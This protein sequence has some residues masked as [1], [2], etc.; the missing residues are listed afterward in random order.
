MKQRMIEMFQKVFQEREE[1]PS[2]G[3]NKKRI[4]GIKGLWFLFVLVVAGA[5]IIGRVV[6]G[7][8]F[9]NIPYASFLLTFLFAAIFVCILA[10]SIYIS[11]SQV[12]QAHKWL[13]EL[14]GE[15]I[16]TWGSG[17]KFPFPFFGFVTIHE[18]YIGEQLMELHMNDETLEGFGYGDVEFVDI[19]APVESTL[20][21]K[22]IDPVKAVYYVENL[23]QA[24]QDKM[25]SA[26]RSFLGQYTIE[27]ANIIRARTSLPYIMNGDYI[28]SKKMPEA[29][30]KEETRERLEASQLYR[31]IYDGWGVEI[32]G[33][34]ISDIVL[35]KDQ[36]EIRRSVLV[37][38][39][40]AEAAKYEKKATIIKASGKRSQLIQEGSGITNQIKLLGK[41][42]MSADS[43]AS[44]LTER[45]KWQNVGEKGAT[46]IE[47]SGKSSMV[48]FGAG[49]GTGFSAAQNNKGGDDSNET[50]R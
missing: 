39:K 49:F 50:N 28:D 41:Q 33:L 38:S 2:E 9:G 29:L 36:K 46:V 42:G 21:F 24:I 34:A 13:I 22:I 12:P 11:W 17:L 20:Y 43:A 4:L 35:D 32:T 19:S 44:Y 7:V 14:F 3:V 27:Q 40:K 23:F 5:L 45:L 31:E 10:T 30:S 47:T 26:T 18:V 15:Y 6:A 25:D 16:A 37:A 8:V 1:D 48:G